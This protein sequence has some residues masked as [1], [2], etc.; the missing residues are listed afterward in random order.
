[1][2]DQ[3]RK[4]LD[5]KRLVEEA[6]VGDVVQVVSVLEDLINPYHHPEH[7]CNL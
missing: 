4:T 1:M 7:V 5:E 3:I 6:L 2:I